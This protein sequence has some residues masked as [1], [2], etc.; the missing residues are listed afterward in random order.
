M[1]VGREG[2]ESNILRRGH[3]K[4]PI[5]DEGVE[6]LKVSELYVGKAYPDPVS[7][8]ARTIQRAGLWRK[9][10]QGMEIPARLRVDANGKE[11]SGKPWTNGYGF[12]DGVKEGD[13]ISLPAADAKLARLL[14]E[15]SEPIRRACTVAPNENQLAAMTVC[16]WNI[17]KEGFLNSSMLKNHNKGDFAA[18]ARCFKL[19]NK[20]GGKIV[21]ALDTRRAAEA[22]LYLK[23]VA[24]E[25]EPVL[26]DDE[27]PDPEI[28]PQTVDKPST[29]LKSPI[30]GS[31]VASGTAGVSMLADVANQIN[32][33]ESSLSVFTRVLG[34]YWPYAAMIAV[35]VATGVVIYYRWKQRHGGWA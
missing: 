28:V 1:A 32:T 6:L 35:V 25:I 5:N 23:P 18:A 7:P 19:W 3:M 11:L 31:A 16:A 26:V 34:P 8:L 20:A 21:P 15:Y 27:V 17:G 13:F 24:N 33:A 30:V 22:A 9:V 4:Y 2:V 12:T 10:L 29:L 14:S